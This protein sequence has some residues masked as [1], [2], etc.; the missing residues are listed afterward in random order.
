MNEHPVDF[1]GGCDR[2]RSSS[3]VEALDAKGAR[4]VLE[5][6]PPCPSWANVNPNEELT[7][8]FTGR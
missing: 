5:R 1:R 8:Q 6:R 7:L 4:R 2:V 3:I